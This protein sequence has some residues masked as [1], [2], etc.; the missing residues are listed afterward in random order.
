M[1]KLVILTCAFYFGPSVCQ[2]N[3]IKWG[4]TVIF[5]N[6]DY[7]GQS[8]LDKTSGTQVPH[9]TG[10]YISKQGTLLYAG[11]WWRGYMHG[12]GNRYYAVS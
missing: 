11:K 8:A 9:G 4:P 3:F 7:Y 6:G 2:E 5:E 12:H 1:L 10:T